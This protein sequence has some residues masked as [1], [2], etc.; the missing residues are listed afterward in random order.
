VGYNN[1]GV[2][3]YN[4]GSY[5]FAEKMWKKARIH[6]NDARSEPARAI[7]LCN[8]SS[9]DSYNN[10]FED[11]ERKLKRAEDIYTKRKDLEGISLVEY[12]RAILDLEKGM[13]DHA[14]DHY[15]R[16]FKIAYPLPF[17][18]EKMERRK[19]FN[20]RTMRKLYIGVGCSR[21]KV[22]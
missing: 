1:W 18:L 4:S 10:R 15:T 22:G 3:R 21:E 19:Q 12:N 5:E 7:V 17:E 20:V 9:I 13:I 14:F 2:L 8:L 16:S 6:A 11:A